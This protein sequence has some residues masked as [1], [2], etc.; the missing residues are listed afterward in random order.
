MGMVSCDGCGIVAIL[1]P[2]T[3]WRTWSEVWD[4]LPRDIK[5]LI[6]GGVLVAGA[7]PRHHCPDCAEYNELLAGG[8]VHGRD[9][10]EAVVYG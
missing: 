1:V 2:N 3:R 8:L 7:V 5:D 4:Q 9:P 6:N 10:S